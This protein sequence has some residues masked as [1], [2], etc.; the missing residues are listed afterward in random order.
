M[1]GSQWNQLPE[2]YGK[3]NSVYRFHL[4]WSKK[5]VF[6]ELLQIHVGRVGLDGRKVIDATHIKV[7]QDACH[8]HESPENQGFGKTKED[9]TR[10]SPPSPTGKEK[11]WPL[12]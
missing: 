1:T 4:R 8:F 12:T 7:H 2:R 3:W 6:S 10:S 5:G 9:E 11:R